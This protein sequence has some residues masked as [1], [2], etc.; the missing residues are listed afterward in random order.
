MKT[1]I[2]AGDA[3]ALLDASIAGELPDAHGR[4]GPFGGR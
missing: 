2:D 3:E 4:C 1:Q